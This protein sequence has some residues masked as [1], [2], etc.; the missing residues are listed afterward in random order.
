M[1]ILFN[2]F[3]HLIKDKKDPYADALLFYKTASLIYPSEVKSFFNENLKEKFNSI[4]SQAKDVLLH[5]SFNIYPELSVIQLENESG[6]KYHD[7]LINIFDSIEKDEA[8]LL[9][10]YLEVGFW[11]DRQNYDLYQLSYCYPLVANKHC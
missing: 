5:Y 6:E 10:Y 2:N 3:M 1:E 4:Q 9:K 8:D 11:L 7:K